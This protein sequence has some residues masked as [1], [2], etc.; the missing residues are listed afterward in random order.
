VAALSAADA[1]TPRVALG[2]DL[3]L[4]GIRIARQPGL[5]PGVSVAIGLYGAD[6]S[7]PL[8]LDAEVVADHGPRGLGLAFRGVSAEQRAALERLV[9]AL[10]LLEALGDEAGSG[11][12]LLVSSVVGQK[13]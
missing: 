3:S 13:A 11:G 10:P 6:G 9:S 12:A 1:G 2:H 5:K 8:T 4:D 7:T